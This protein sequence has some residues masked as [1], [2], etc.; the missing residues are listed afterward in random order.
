MNQ[1]VQSA[2]SFHCYVP[3]LVT[4]KLGVMLVPAESGI[5]RAFSDR[6]F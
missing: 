5:Y 6:I 4:L 1:E 3:F 2:A